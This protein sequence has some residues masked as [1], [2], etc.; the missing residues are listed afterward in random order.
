MEE[1]EEGFYVSTSTLCNI[2]IQEVLEVGLVVSLQE[3]VDFVFGKQFR[4]ERI[5]NNLRQLYI[6]NKIKCAEDL[7]LLHGK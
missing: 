4:S 5:L 7:C 6:V 1:V 2:F 3:F